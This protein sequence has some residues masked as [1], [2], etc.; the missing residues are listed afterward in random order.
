MNTREIAKFLGT[1]A[2]VIE[3]RLKR[4]RAKMKEEMIAMMTESFKQGKLQAGFTFRLLEMIKRVRIQQVPRMPW[5][6]WGIPVAS[7]ILIAVIS[8]TL[9]LFSFSPISIGSMLSDYGLLNN[10][11]NQID[12]G[13]YV[14]PYTHK[15]EMVNYASIP[16]TLETVSSSSEKKADKPAN[17]QGEIQKP[18]EKQASMG[19]AK[20]G[21]VKLQMKPWI[22]EEQTSQSEVESKITMPT[23]W[24][25]TTKIKGES[26]SI[27]LGVDNAGVMKII[28]TS[29]S[30]DPE[31]TMENIPP[32]QAKFIEEAMK[33]GTGLYSKTVSVSRMRPDGTVIDNSL[34]RMMFAV[35][36]T[37]STGQA[38]DLFGFSNLQLS[39]FPDKPI[40]VGESWTQQTGTNNNISTK[41]TLLGF[42]EIQGQKCAKI[43][44]EMTMKMPQI[45]DIIISSTSSSTEY[46][47]IED[48]LI[49]KSVGVIDTIPNQQEQGTTKTSQTTELVKRQKLTPDEFKVI[50][51]EAAELEIAFGYLIKGN[52]DSAKEAIQKFVDT[53]PQS[54]FKDGVEG[55]IT[56]INTVKKMS[57]KMQS[58]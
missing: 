20:E 56:Q 23:G 12:I 13:R 44:I 19:I 29:R 41:S 45:G 6:P 24:I 46:F 14:V 16:V 18:E 55:L 10:Q 7:S 28:T 51:D 27:C 8:I 1:S 33:Q 3:Q 35:I 22:G 37:L 17:I 34:S 50:Q 54:R 53:H 2:N 38:S 15:G 49:V 42:D 57:E 26:T 5:L 43:Q 31:Q 11:S 21:P 36:G 30:S 47:S 4:A 9:N 39:M 58:K 32:D 48:G 25:I 40:S 52:F